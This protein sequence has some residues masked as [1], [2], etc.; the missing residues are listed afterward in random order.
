M[1][2]FSS[3]VIEGISQKSLKDDTYMIA[4]DTGQCIF[5]T[6]NRSCPPATTTLPLVT[7]SSPAMTIIADR[8]SCPARP[9]HGNG[10]TR[11]DIEAHVIQD[12]NLPGTAG[13]ER[14][15]VSRLI[16]A[17]VEVSFITV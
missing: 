5:I 7:F 12:I 13:I 11:G 3:A 16:M 9:K 8:L 1:A 4:A 6:G 2:V 17:V 15:T 10:F 14:Q